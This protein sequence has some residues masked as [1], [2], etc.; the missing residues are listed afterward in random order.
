MILKFP[1]IDTLRLA[2]IDGAVPAAASQDAAAAG[3]D[4]E[5]AVWIDTSA[6]LSKKEQA[7]LRRLGVQVAKKGNSP[8][9]MRKIRHWLEMIPLQREGE[10]LASPEQSAVLFDLPSGQQLARMAIEILRLGNDRQSYRWL[11]ATDGKKDEGEVR[12][13]LR[14]VGPPYYSLLR[15]LD[16]QGPDATRAFVEKVVGSRVWVE[17]GWTHPL[18]GTIKAPPGQMVLLRPPGRWTFLPEGP[19]RDV[20]EVMEFAL[21]GEKLGWK[22][23][24]VGQKLK[25]PLTLTRSGTEAAEL[26][27]L[28]DDP[29]AELNNLV[30]NAEYD[31]LNR[32][33]FAVGENCGKQTIVLKAR[34]SK[35]PPPVLVIKGQAF[36]P[37]RALPNLFLPCGW[38]L[39]PPLRRDIVR[40]FL[41]DDSGVLTWLYPGAGNKFVPETLPQDA[42]RPL[43]DWIDYIIEH[44]REALQ[45][46]VASTTFDFESFV[47]SEDEPS[48][49]KKPPAPERGRNP[50][51][52][53]NAGAALEA[54]DMPDVKFGRA[55][56]EALVEEDDPAP[57][58]QNVQPSEL[59]IKLEALEE[60]FVEI[61]GE[62]DVEERKALW[63]E[64]ANL[65]MLLKQT[66]DASICWMNALWANDLPPSRWLWA[67]YQ[68]EAA[69]VPQRQDKGQRRSYLWVA[70]SIQGSGPREVSGDDLDRVLSLP[71]PT[72]S[73]VRALGAYLAWAARR[74]PHPPTLMERLN[75]VQRFL[76]AH[77]SLLSI[78]ATWLAWSAFVHLT[79]GD[80]LAL[81]RA[82]D[83]LL[84]RLFRNGLRPEQ[85][86]P[87]FLRYSGQPTS[88][89]YRAV[90][91]WMSQ[92][93]GMAHAWSKEPAN[94]SD[95]AREET[96]AYINLI[97]AYG[98]A[99]LGEIEA[100][101]KLQEEAKQVLTAKDEAHQ[102]LCKA[103]A[104]RIKMAQEGKRNSGPLPTEDLK[105][106]E[107]LEQLGHKDAR[108]KRYVVE[109]LWQHSRILEP[110]QKIDPY[111]NWNAR[112]SDL[113]KALADLT[114]LTDRREIAERVQRLLQS[115]A[116][117]GNK[118]HEA[119]VSILST[120][121]NLAP[122]VNEEFALD[123]LAQLL[124]TYDSLPE[125]KDAVVLEQQARLLEK[126]LFVAAH[127]DRKD[128]VQALVNRFASL[129]QSQ[130]GNAGA[131][132]TLDTLAEHSFRGLRKL[133]MREEIDVLLRRMA[134][135][136]LDGRDVSTFEGILDRNG[137][138]ALRALLHVAGGWLYFGRERQAEPIINAVRSR[139]FKNEL[140][141]REQAP[142]A[143]AYAL[144]VGQAPVEAAQKLLEELFRRLQGIKGILTTSNHYCLWQLDVVEAVVMAVVNEDSA[145][146]AD[147]RRWLDDDEFIVRRRLHRDFHAL[148]AQA[149]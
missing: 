108:L 76:E 91:Q 22:E 83:R 33:S 69:P 34:L 125:V 43:T 138:V 31:L 1:D 77:E 7:E 17:L 102:A 3:L 112:I 78:R 10:G 13:L 101:R 58:L 49:P 103:Y 139:L 60:R 59:K 18:I 127:F 131:I 119:R 40:K 135:A 122:R 57:A 147:A 39:H 51:A 84:E 115:H 15:A 118:G 52:G 2:L 93:C 95:Q 28:R 110:D 80:V 140:H 42:F 114:D 53:K 145:M 47:C 62:L 106:L 133:G 143:R 44:D 117:K 107:Q 87:S 97:F 130:R 71:D 109:R 54:V 90:R 113:E 129:L 120:A 37:F 73:D 100:S 99:R 36:R 132:Q 24:E 5:G 20:Y 137:A 46:W 86:L 141:A 30:Q 6:S 149:H 11:E 25:V 116:P 70:Q 16:P 55:Q 89:R 66:D 68:T 128:T 144:T 124:P 4:D 64:M 136:I 111:R 126:G 92:L 142:L 63:P 23:G 48:K 14:V 88:Q 8:V 67:W 27:V 41:A 98:L 65:N 104:Y 26:W 96:Q 105:H 81:A 32:L 56:K 82:R 85:D 121:L 146:G 50:N 94:A 38:S 123:M 29:I 19:F 148:K 12:A 134:E 61:E 72:L 74:M 79:G 75:T 9:A 21:P 45:A 35:M